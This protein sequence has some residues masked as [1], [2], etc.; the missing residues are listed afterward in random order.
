M[1]KVKIFTLYP[2]LFPGLLDSGMYKKAREK[3]IW[4]LEVINIRDY[5]NDKHRTVDDTPFGGGSGM[6]IRPDVLAEALDK[7]TTT[8]EIRKSNASSIKTRVA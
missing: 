1:L 3:K 5:T 6:L 2:D 4:D 7:N 8:K